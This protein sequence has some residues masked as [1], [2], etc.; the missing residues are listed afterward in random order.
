M[1]PNRFLPT[2]CILVLSCMFTMTSCAMFRPATGYP[3][4]DTVIPFESSQDAESA[5]KTDNTTNSETYADETEPVEPETLVANFVGAGDNIIYY[6]NVRDAATYAINNGRTYNFKPS[7]QDV[8]GLIQEAD[9]AFINQETLMCGNGYAFSYYPMFNGPQDLAY[10]LVETGFDVINIANNHMLD[11]GADGL[12]ATIDFWRTF[13]DITCIGGYLNEEEYSRIAIREVKGIRIA[14]LTFTFMTNGLSLPS[15]SEMVVPYRDDAV[16][17]EQLESA[18]QIADYVIVS[19]HWGDENNFTPNSEQ[20]EFAKLLASNG[21]DVILGH[22]P[23]VIQPIE[24]I[25][26]EN[27]TRT[28][29]VYSLG[30]FMAEMSRDYNML[31]GMISFDI[32]K[33]GSETT[34]E[35]VRFIP[36]VFYFT[37]SFYQ[38][39][40]YLLSDFTDELAASHGLAYYGRS[41]SLPTLQQY[42]TNTIDSM[43]LVTNDS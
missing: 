16:A 2:A 31:G 1:K 3:E 27:G 18:N 40:I 38:N 20:R 28:L 43:F 6:G 33:T 8:A 32:V 26:N 37:T 36:T 12:A 4:T 22:H 30:N 25:E 24:W 9:I 42:L 11:K 39:R 14:F 7:Y 34:T 5:K 23:H 10:D 21:A 41:L 17:I 19:V 35:N 13:D 29:C 15:S